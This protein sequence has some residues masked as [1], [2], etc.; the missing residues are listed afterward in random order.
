M[1]NLFAMRFSLTLRAIGGSLEP[2]FF[3]SQHFAAAK[4]FLPASARRKR[5]NEHEGHQI[6]IKTVSIFAGD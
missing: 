1:V 5:N 3:R 4:G 2:F 6:V